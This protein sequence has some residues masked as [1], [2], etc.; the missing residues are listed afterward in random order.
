MAQL[1]ELRAGLT[2]S[3]VPAVV[4]GRIAGQYAK[5]R[6]AASRLLVRGSGV[7][8]IAGYRGGIV[9]DVS[10]DPPSRTPDPGVCS[11]R[12]TTLR[13][14]CHRCERTQWGTLVRAQAFSR[15]TKRCSSGTKS[16]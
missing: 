1:R 8:E 3:R 16:H 11:A 5:P 2:G 6:S 4:I 7:T 14:P 9:N 10:P 13:R 12:T 15:R